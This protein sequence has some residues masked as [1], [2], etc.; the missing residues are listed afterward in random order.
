MNKKQKELVIKS[1]L[2][3]VTMYFTQAIYWVR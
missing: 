2:Q 1:V 3:S